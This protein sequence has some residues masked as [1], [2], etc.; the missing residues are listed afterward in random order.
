MVLD[1]LDEV[2]PSCVA[3]LASFIKNQFGK[4]DIQVTNAA[5]TGVIMDSD[6]ISASAIDVWDEV[7]TQTY[8]LAEDCLETN[9]YGAKRMTEALIPL[10]ELSD[11][12]RIVNVSSNATH[13]RVVL[14]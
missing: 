11:S 5:I 9:Y 1:L 13:Q 6:A 14:P 4:L 10:L 12:P 2:E 8:N 7:T 3:S